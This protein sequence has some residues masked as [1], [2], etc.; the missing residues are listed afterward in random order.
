M[1]QPYFSVN[2]MQISDV[3]MENVHPNC[4][5]LSHTTKQ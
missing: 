3:N 2:T 5:N 4:D 1:S